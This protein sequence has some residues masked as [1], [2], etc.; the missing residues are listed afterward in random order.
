[1][2]ARN[3]PSRFS[4][5]SERFA[6]VLRTAPVENTGPGQHDPIPACFTTFESQWHRFLCKTTHPKILH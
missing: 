6:T 4:V 5:A 2:A 1:M 3:K